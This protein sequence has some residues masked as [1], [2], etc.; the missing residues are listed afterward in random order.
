MPIGSAGRE[1][2][3]GI[4]VNRE[5]AEIYRL[6]AGGEGDP[7]EEARARIAGWGVDRLAR[8]YAG[9]RVLEEAMLPVVEARTR[10]LPERD[11]MRLVLDLLVLHHDLEGAVIDTLAARFSLAGEYGRET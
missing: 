3:G 4:Q 9:L 10:G 1:T 2:E 7:L 6:L 5:T 11:G 8:L